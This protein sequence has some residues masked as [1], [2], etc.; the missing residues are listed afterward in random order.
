MPFLHGN[1]KSQLPRWGRGLAFKEKR[2]RC[3]MVF[4]WLGGIVLTRGR[5]NLQYL[6]ALLLNE[7][8][9]QTLGSGNA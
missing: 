7:F 3:L 1:L 9:M 2:Q 4:D 6:H 5:L 8:D